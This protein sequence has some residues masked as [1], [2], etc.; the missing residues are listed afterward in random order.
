VCVSDISTRPSTRRDIIKRN[1]QHSYYHITS[2]HRHISTYIHSHHTNTAAHL[3]NTSKRS[4]VKTLTRQ[5]AVVINTLT[6]SSHQHINCVTTHQLSFYLHINTVANTSTACNH[7]RLNTM[8]SPQEVINTS[9]QLLTHQTTRNSPT[10]SNAQIR[11]L[12]EVFPF[13]HPLLHY[14]LRLWVL[15]RT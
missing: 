11:Y 8:S 4:H 10:V 15:V 14:F 3:I 5:R 12:F 7:Q 6:Q 1:H 13:S 9:T 2:V